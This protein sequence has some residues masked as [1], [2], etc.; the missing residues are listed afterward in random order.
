MSKMIV[1]RALYY[2]VPPPGDVS[3]YSNDNVVECIKNLI[4]ESIG[5]WVGPFPVS[6]LNSKKKLVYIADVKFVP[7]RS[8]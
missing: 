7:P 4:S 1:D 2:A 5:Y 8:F 6:T 3:F